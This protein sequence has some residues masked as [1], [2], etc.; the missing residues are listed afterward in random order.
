MAPIFS[1][2]TCLPTT[3][4]TVAGTGACT[5]GYYPSYAINVS[6]GLEIE[7]NSI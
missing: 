3:D 7:Q 6:K 4:P 5:L 1:N 2:N